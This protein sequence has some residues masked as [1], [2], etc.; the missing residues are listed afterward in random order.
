MPVKIFCF[1]FFAF[2]LLG[3]QSSTVKDEVPAYPPLVKHSDL[4]PSNTPK[5]VVMTANTVKITTLEKNI[6]KE[7]DP[8]AQPAP[9]VAPSPTPE[10]KEVKPDAEK[11]EKM[12][13]KIEAPKIEPPKI[14]PKKEKYHSL[15]L[16]ALD[17]R[18]YYHGQC[19]KIQEYLKTQNITDVFIYEITNKDGKK[20]W[21]V[22]AGKF[23]SDKTP[24]AKEFV[25]KM[26]E[27]KFENKAQ[28]NQAYFV[29]RNG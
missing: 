28:F 16:I 8:A 5:D 21:V 4:P 27:L 9:A 29:L 6:I 1:I 13:L 25:K 10:K 3:C 24:E 22:D 7:P 12:P 18:P 17:H 23:S 14:E 11:E 2:I 26:H 15:R 19:V 20:F